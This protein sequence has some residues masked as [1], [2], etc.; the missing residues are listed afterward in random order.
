[1]KVGNEAQIQDCVHDNIL[2][3]DNNYHGLRL[4]IH[5]VED[6]WQRYVVSLHLNLLG[7]KMMCWGAS[8]DFARAFP[9]CP[10]GRQRE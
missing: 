5:C 1:M 9:H 6:S 3:N 10:K 4:H 2:V 8:Q 7:P